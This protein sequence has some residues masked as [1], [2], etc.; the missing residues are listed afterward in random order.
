MYFKMTSKGAKV[1][2]FYLTLIQFLP[3]VQR[4]GWGR[5]ENVRKPH[6]QRIYC[7]SS[8]HAVYVNGHIV[9]INSVLV[10]QV[11]LQR[12][13]P[14]WAQF[15]KNLRIMGFDSWD[16]K[17]NGKD[18]FTSGAQA[19]I[20]RWSLSQKP[21]IIITVCVFFYLITL[22]NFATF[23]PNLP[24]HHPLFWVICLLHV[25]EEFKPQ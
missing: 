9:T 17:K 7:G 24:S 6:C 2:W 20:S 22:Y 15:I 1:G 5:Y 4:E 19:S 8:W 18:C 21:T 16:W 3:S 13:S 11:F 23:V 14:Q 10:T 25:V 12:I